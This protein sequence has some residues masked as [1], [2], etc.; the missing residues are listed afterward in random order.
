MIVR[1]KVACVLPGTEVTSYR[2]K[3]VAFVLL[4]ERESVLLLAVTYKEYVE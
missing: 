2:R 4:V 3:L 1:V